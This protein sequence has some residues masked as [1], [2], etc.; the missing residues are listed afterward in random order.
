VIEK[1]IQLDEINLVDFLG[2]EDRNI[3]TLAALFPTAKLI[4]RG[5]SIKIQGS[6]EIV[7]K[8]Y[9]IIQ[10]L[11]E[12]YRSQNLIT[13]E[14]VHHYAKQQDKVHDEPLKQGATILHTAKG[15]PINPRSANQRKI[16]TAVH[17]HA[18]TFV[19]GVAG[20]GKT[21]ISM[22]LAI[23]ALKR[24][25]VERIV[26]TRPIVEAGENLGFLPGYLEEKT[27]PYLYPIYDALDDIISI[28]K[29]K[30]YQETGI[31]EVAPLAYMRGRTLHNAFVVLD[32]AQNTTA[33]QMKMF[34][35]RM[36]VHSKFIIT[37][38]PTQ[39]DLP[40]TKQ[41]G[42]IEAIEVLKSVEGISF[43]YLDEKDIVR[44]PLIKSII[45]AYDNSGK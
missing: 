24:K 22:A 16:V 19:V 38:D 37:G 31:I 41:S 17:E 30:Y 28:E 39:I 3:A 20:T 43:I 1:I 42:L 21:Y 32:E 18:L 34:L 11:L 7:E 9:E 45:Q 15:K 14:L 40:R 10:S 44:H 12:H 27:A 23:Q 35:T 6:Q 33:K 29:R 26:V 8:L 2:V 5:N 4:S 13:Q 25:E 36:G